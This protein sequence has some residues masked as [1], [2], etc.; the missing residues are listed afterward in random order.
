M[1]QFSASNNGIGAPISGA[2]PAGTYTREA[3]FW[4]YYEVGRLGCTWNSRNAMSW[5]AQ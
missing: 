5:A 3:G 1:T 4:A 2:G